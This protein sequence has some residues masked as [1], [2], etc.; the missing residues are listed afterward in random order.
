MPFIVWTRRIGSREA[1][2][3]LLGLKGLEMGRGDVFEG[4]QEAASL[5]G[6]GVRQGGALR[7][8]I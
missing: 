2:L 7:S 6:K 3:G 4:E 8:P 1:S 5:S